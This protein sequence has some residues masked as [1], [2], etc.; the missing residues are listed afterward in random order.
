MPQLTIVAHGDSGAVVL[1]AA[2]LESIG[3]RIGDVVDVTLSDRQLIFRPVD[4]A[5][6]RRLMEEITSDVLEQRRDAYR[7]LA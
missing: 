2:L 5:A 7:R 6:R 1:P 3:L 4:D